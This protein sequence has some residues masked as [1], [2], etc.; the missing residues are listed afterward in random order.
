MYIGVDIGGTNLVAGLVNDDC[1]IIEK[2]KTPT[3]PQRGAEEVLADVARL[4]HELAAKA[5]IGMD[6]VKWVGVGSPGSID[7]ENGVFVFAGNLPFRNTPVVKILGES[8]GRPIYVGNDANAAALGEV[9]AGAAKD[10]DSALLF[11]LGTGLGGGIVINRRIYSG[12]NGDGGEVGHMV[13]E[14]DGCPCTCGRNGCWEAYSSATGLIRMT[15]EAMESDKKSLLYAAAAEEGKVSA[16]TAF[17]AARKGDPSARAVVDK[18]I[19]YLAAG[20]ANMIN[21][22][23]PEMVCIGGGVC[24]EGDYLMLPLIEQTR[25]EQFKGSPKQTLIRVAELGNDAG[26]IGAAMLG[27]QSC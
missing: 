17:V 25:K 1:Q 18:Y 20:L 5:G 12:F 4:C 15:R 23:Q 9:Y 24:N 19:K 26:V 21:V 3:K 27:K 10:C 22:F 8:I 16:R 11:T 7:A 6:E 2:L 13:V 14:V